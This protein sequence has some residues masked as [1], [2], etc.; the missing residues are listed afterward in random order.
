MP[1]KNLNSFATNCAHNYNQQ[2]NAG[3]IHIRGNSAIRTSETTCS[4]YFA[5][6]VGFFT[7]AI[8]VGGP[9]GT[10]NIICEA[11]NCIYYENTRCNAEVVNINSH[12]S[13][14]ETFK[15]R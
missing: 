8:E 1:E 11:S 13:S 5:D 15:C 6:S 14:C 9:T 3:T 12:F 2:C 7:R 10:D 4:T